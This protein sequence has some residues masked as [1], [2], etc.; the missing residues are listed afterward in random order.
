[1]R[2]GL[3]R[4]SVCPL[5]WGLLFALRSLENQSLQL[6]QLYSVVSFIWR[7]L[8]WW[9]EVQEG[10]SDV[11]CQPLW[12]STESCPGSQGVDSSIPAS[13]CRPG[14]PASCP[15]L[16]VEMGSPLSQGHRFCCFSPWRL[17]LIFRGKMRRGVYVCGR[18]S[19][20]VA[21]PFL[22]PHNEGCARDSAHLPGQCLVGFMEK[23]L[24]RRCR[25]LCLCSPEGLHALML[26]HTWPLD[27]TE[28]F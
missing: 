28:H 17:Q 18:W 11:L 16:T 4:L 13:T 22:S 14:S 21:A 8:G 19:Q 15:L 10:R 5:G 3:Q 1:M 24:A 7:L 23:K 20:V 26:A 27:V 9:Q 25:S 6:S 12:A 2:A